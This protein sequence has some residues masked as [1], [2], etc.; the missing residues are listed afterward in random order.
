MFRNLTHLELLVSDLTEKGHVS[1]FIMKVVSPTYDIAA[2]SEGQWWIGFG[3]QD[4]AVRAASFYADTHEADSCVC[5]QLQLPSCCTQ[6]LQ[7]SHVQLFSWFKYT[8]D[9][10]TT[11]SNSDLTKGSNPWPSDHEQYI[12]YPWNAVVWTTWPSR[13]LMFARLRQMTKHPEFRCNWVQTPNL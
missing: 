4:R 11:H 8:L 12:S 6:H 1:V 9:R 2:A 3:S 13:P 10:S 7:N 5:T